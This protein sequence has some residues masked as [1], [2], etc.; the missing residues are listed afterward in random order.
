MRGV[1][2]HINGSRCV[3]YIGLFSS[4]DI[5]GTPNT[6]LLKS[7][8]HHLADV[9]KASSTLRIASGTLAP[10]PFFFSHDPFNYSGLPVLLEVL[11]NVVSSVI[12]TV[13]NL[14]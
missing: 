5:F 2:L 9:T 8:A 1:A 6:S 3:G 4:I 10:T 11:Q 12:E 13:T 14:F 7:F